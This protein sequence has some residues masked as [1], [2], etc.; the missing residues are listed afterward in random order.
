M[1]PDPKRTRQAGHRRTL[2]FGASAAALSLG[3]LCWLSAPAAASAADLAED[4]PIARPS[5]A[6]APA[7]APQPPAPVAQTPPQA[8][9]PAP[10]P[11]S[12]SQMD[13]FSKNTLSLLL[14]ARLVVANGAPSFIH[15]GFGKTLFQGDKNGNY[16]AQV[17]PA[18]ADL[19]WEPRFSN[20]LSAN[21]S[22]AAQRYQERGV[23]LLEAF[24][25]YLP[26]QTGPVGISARAGLMWPEISLEHST[27]GA[28][29]VVNT[30]TPSAINSWVGEE[31]KVV[32]GEL[33]LH[34]GIKEHEFSLTGAAFG[35]NDTSGTLLSFR[36]WSLQ[37][38]KATTFGHFP[39]PPLNPYITQLQQHQTKSLAEIDGKV[40]FYGRFDWRPPWPVG[41]ALFYY[42]NNGDPQAFDKNFQWGWRTRFFNAGLNADLTPKTHLLAQIMTGSTIMGFPHNGA[43]WVHTQFDSAYVMV[44][45][46][47]GPLAI[48][49][50]AEDFSTHE[51]GSQ[52]PPSN[53]ENGWA[54]TAAARVPINK[55][56]TTLFEALNVHSNRGA[57]VD[58]GG[59]ESRFESQTTFQASIRVRL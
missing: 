33:T 25:N 34:A 32:G 54:L 17:V 23:D 35:F 28:W 42:D 29:T 1:T 12:G 21:V 51:S 10:P 14:D 15:N 39:L 46:N 4:A 6:E 50:R 53:S 19:V 11:S 48:S 49:G 8:T 5:Q 18:E 3:S 30:I 26:S 13:L 41:V 40:G 59:L 38:E 9:A 16:Q 52:M 7:P 24:L 44:T 37:D 57:R 36:G 31:V 2:S 43:P 58:L 56:V 55:Y 27:G 20:S 47:I 22:A 45:R